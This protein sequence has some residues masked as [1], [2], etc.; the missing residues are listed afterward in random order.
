[1]SFS[2]R[3]RV[4]ASKSLRLG[5]KLLRGHPLDRGLHLVAQVGQALVARDVQLR[6]EVAQ[7]PQ[8]LKERGVEP[9]GVP[10]VVGDQPVGHVLDHGPQAR[11]DVAHRAVDLVLDVLSRSGA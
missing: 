10:V 4:L 8:I 3:R 11:V 1:M 2:T 7:F 6:D 9:L 5:P